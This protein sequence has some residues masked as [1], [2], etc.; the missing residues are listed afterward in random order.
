MLKHGGD[1]VGFMERYGVRPLDFF[2]IVSPL[3]MPEGVREAAAE[4]LADSAAYPDPLCRA[5]RGALSDRLHV[6]QEKILCGAGA[7]DLVY[8]LVAARKP[9]G[10]LV[11]APA[12]SGYE[13]ALAFS[14]CGV[15]RFPLDGDFRLTEDIA[16]RITDRTELV[17]L[18]Q[19]NNPSGVTVPADLLHEILDRCTAAGALLVLD[20]CFLEF[21]DDPGSCTLLPR[22][23][24]G[25][26]LILRAFTKFYGMAGLRLGYCLCADTD[27]LG[28]MQLAGPVWGVSNVAQAAGLAALREDGYAARLRTLIR[29]ERPRLAR[30]LR[31]LGLR[32][33]PGEANFLLFRADASLGQRLA[34]RGIL[35]RD[36]RDMHGLGPGWY[37]TAV[38]TPEE[39]DRLTAALKEVL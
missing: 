17:F 32:V 37:R 4:A 10:A 22:L 14:G 25:N 7:M 2:A 9:A 12:F 30:A 36:C 6:A 33:V 28:R 38:R 27:L 39:N 24:S 15:S 19:P 8:R 29:R 23:D 13:E 5:L 3:G 16:G 35:L 21:L 26:L 31:E 34:Q 11:T 18:C 1:R 20:E